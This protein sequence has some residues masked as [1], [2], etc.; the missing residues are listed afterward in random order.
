M[1]KVPSPRGARPRHDI[2]PRVRAAL[3]DEP[4]TVTEIAERAG[5]PG[6]DRG[7]HAARALARLEA[8][9]L[10]VLVG[11]QRHPRWRTPQR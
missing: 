5:M 6:R 8:E 4:S 10:A 3:T 2:R 7:V 9:G 11:D 1:P